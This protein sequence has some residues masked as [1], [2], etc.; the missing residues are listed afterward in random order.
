MNVK[1]WIWAGP[2][3]A[4]TCM[5][6]AESVTLSWRAN[7]ETNLVG[8]RVYAGTNSRQYQICIPTALVT[9]QRVDLPVSGR[10]F[11]AVSATNRV[12]RESAYSTEVVLEPRPEAPVIDGRPW[13]KLTPVIERSTN[14]TNWASV[15]AAPTWLL[16]TNV[17][18]FFTTRRLEI[19]RVERVEAQ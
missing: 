11:F 15:P 18:E 5:L 4:A 7:T 17:Q 13:V 10:W 19:E 1:K 16:A 6:G 14:Q 2:L 3:L 9:T 8:Y 12:G